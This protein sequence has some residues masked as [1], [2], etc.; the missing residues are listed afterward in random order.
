[1]AGVKPNMRTTSLAMVLSGVFLSV[2]ASGPGLDRVVTRVFAQVPAAPPAAGAPQ[3]R[4]GLGRGAQGQPAPGQAQGGA[5]DGGRQAQP[6]GAPG[7][8]GG[9][10]RGP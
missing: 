9:R 2:L 1:M 5:P 10:G 3:G 8:G 7:A 6:P 4:G